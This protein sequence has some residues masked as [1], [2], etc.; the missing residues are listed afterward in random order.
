[1]GRLRLFG[2]PEGGGTD[3]HSA[4][5]NLDYAHSGHSGFVPSQG[6][7]L[8]EILRVTSHM[9]VAC[10]PAAD[11]F[12]RVEPSGQ[13]LANKTLAK[14]QAMSATMG[15]GTFRALTGTVP[16]SIGS[17]AAANLRAL[18]F[19]VAAAAGGGGATADMRC[20]YNQLQVIAFSGSVLQMVNYWLRQPVMFGG[21]PSVSLVRGIYIENQG[22]YSAISDV[23]SLKIEDITSNTGHKYLIEAGPS[24][25]YLRLVGGGDPPANKSNLYLKFG[26]TLYRVVKSGD[27]MTLETA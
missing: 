17:G 4:L 26:S 5:S 18:E 6:E 19:A 12:L 22:G 24:T 8:V 2:E 1:M 3:D 23:E 25:P 13:N 7:A 16:V 11:V 9:A 10:L 14:V 20:M 27:Y 15:S 21:S